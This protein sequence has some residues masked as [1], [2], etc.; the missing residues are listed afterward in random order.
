MMELAS[1]TVQNMPDCFRREPITVL[2]P[3]S[4]TPEP[5]NKM[6]TAEVWV[7]PTVGIS[8]EIVGLRA[9]LFQNFGVGDSVERNE[10]TSFSISPYRSGAFDGF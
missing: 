1:R 8:L 6:L 10:R 4:I 2:Q 9:N 5:M 3:A 7:S